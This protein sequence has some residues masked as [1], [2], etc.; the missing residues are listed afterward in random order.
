MRRYRVL[1]LSLALLA[2]A[3]LVATVLAAGGYDLSWHTVDGGGGTSSGGNYVLSGTIGQPDAGTLSGG[4]YNLIGGFWGRV[5]G[6]MDIGEY[7]L[8]LPV[9]MRNN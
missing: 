9:I 8:Y 3:L 2:S 7:R 1:F 6:G 4:T 5:G